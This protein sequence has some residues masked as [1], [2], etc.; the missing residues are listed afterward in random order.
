M[1]SSGSEQVEHQHYRHHWRLPALH[2]QQGPNSTCVAF[3]TASPHV[4][5]CPVC[6]SPIDLTAPGGKNI[7]FLSCMSHIAILASWQCDLVAASS[8]HAS[9]AAQK[10]ALVLASALASHTLTSV[11]ASW[12]RN[13]LLS[14]SAHHTW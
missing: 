2:S 1:R 5:T 3:S 8:G 4:D 10:E 7:Y 14:Y 12:H 6:S 13:A 9:K 11:P